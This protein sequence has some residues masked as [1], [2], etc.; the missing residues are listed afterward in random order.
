VQRAPLEP[1]APRPPA[2]ADPTDPISR[3]R[4]RLLLAGGRECGI[5]AGSDPLQG[6]DPMRARH[7][8]S[9][10]AAAAFC[11][12]IP[13]ADAGKDWK[14]KFEPGMK[15]TDSNVRCDTVKDVEPNDKGGVKALFAVLAGRDLAWIDWHIRAA[16]I[17]RLAETSDE[18]ALA[19]IEKGLQSKDPSIRE[20]SCAALGK[21]KD[22]KA[23]DPIARL[24]DDKDPAV[25]RAAI[26]AI[27]EY[28]DTKSIDA[29]LDRWERSAKARDF[30]EVNLC[31]D[32]VEAIT[33][34]KRP[35]DVKEWKEWWSNA[36][37]T[38]KRR[39]DMTDDERAK[40]DEAG[41]KAEEEQR[42][43]EEFTTTLRDMPVTF[44]VEGQG[45]IPLLVI[46]DDSWRPTYFDPYLAS[47]KDICRI[48]Y[49]DL[50]SIT[51]LDKTKL[52]KDMNG[53]MYYYPY[54]Q[55][56]DAFDEIRKQYVK[57]KFAVLAHGFSTMVAER[58]MSKHGENVS[59]AI[60]VG[61]FPGDDA[62]GNMLDKLS[63]KAT[64]QLKDVELRHAVDFHYVNDT[65]TKKTFYTPK[66]DAELEALERKFFAIQF[67]NPQDPEIEDIWQRCK[68]PANVSKDANKAE[69][70]LSPPFDILRE[71]KPNCPVLVISGA[72]S[73]WFGPA[74]GDRVAKN[75]PNGQHVV[76]KE[77]AMMPWFDEPTAFEDAVRK[78][79][80]DH[81]YQ[82]AKAGS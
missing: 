67:A 56:C 8:L 79:F 7:A 20:A 49:V 74:D 44:T 65:K 22:P 5:I 10:L 36:A 76:L 23:A 78:F 28:R 66:N 50:P 58:Y 13:S 6:A 63:A 60:L 2:E 52:K 61:C 69:E 73:I 25:R 64:G 42:K 41:Q 81:P 59:H 15:N 40:A 14:Q 38:F 37:G 1:N 27:T 70:C 57:D 24:L 51:K 17:A 11:L 39:S 29:L 54:D 62:Y 16:A 80:K 34:L 26:R 43:K 19:E 18:K 55:L 9:A 21:L 45:E 68:R 71:K 75:F 48:Y 33:E 4:G 35:R 46:H 77:T 53:G 30:R 3:R 47:L 72:K 31:A 32:A 12:A 82:K